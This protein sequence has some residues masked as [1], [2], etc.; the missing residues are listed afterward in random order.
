MISI[1]GHRH[2]FADACGAR[3][4]IK[5]GIDVRVRGAIGPR[6]ADAIAA[7]CTNRGCLYRLSWAAASRQLPA[8]RV[9][10]WRRL[11]GNA[12]CALAMRNQNTT[13]TTA[14]NTPHTITNALIICFSSETDIGQTDLARSPRPRSCGRPGSSLSWRNTSQNL[15]ALLS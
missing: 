6:E 3:P 11:G 10:N 15:I 9:A 1:C 14:A 8:S 4:L 2:V 13:M 12:S 5:S 7:G